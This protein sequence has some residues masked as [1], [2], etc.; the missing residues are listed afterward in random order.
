[1]IG[2]FDSIG[3]LAVVASPENAEEL[4]GRADELMCQIKRS[5]R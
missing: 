3:V 2:A 4:V 5:G 1:V